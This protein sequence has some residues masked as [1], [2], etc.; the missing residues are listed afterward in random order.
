LFLASHVVGGK[1]LRF[2]R[3]QRLAFSPIVAKDLTHYTYDSNCSF[4]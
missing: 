3:Q 4:L 1:N 2:S